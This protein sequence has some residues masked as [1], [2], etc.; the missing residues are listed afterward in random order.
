MLVTVGTDDQEPG[1]FDLG[2]I[3]K[4]RLDEEE[5]LA[6][7]DFW[8]IEDVEEPSDA[9][10]LDGPTHSGG[11]DNQLAAG[12]RPFVWGEHEDAD[13]NPSGAMEMAV[14]RAVN[15]DPLRI[16][17]KQTNHVALLTAEEE[18]DLGKR[19]EAG[20]YAAERL[21]ASRQ[22]AESLDSELRHDLECIQREGECAKK[23]LIEA[24]LRLVVSIARRYRALGLP[25]MDLI[26]EGNLGLIRAVQKFDYTKGFEVSTYATWWIR[27]AITRG[28]ADS[29]RVIRLPV[30]V[31]EHVN[32]VQQLERGYLAEHGALPTA[33]WLAESLHVGA[34]QVEHLRDIALTT[35]AGISWSRFSIPT[36]RAGWMR[37]MSARRL[38]RILSSIESA[39]RCCGAPFV[40]WGIG[41]GTSCSCGSDG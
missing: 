35:S 10:Q 7:L 21:R 36:I 18:V 38:R 31:V 27:Q 23:Q 19:I 26:Q 24:N 14:A 33:C 9:G 4:L 8:E 6:D 32:A 13:R 28:L 17:L 16:Y 40:R 15:N 1:D 20:L 37:S 25:L 34:D 41:P 3:E 29:A 30:H 12:R 22:A 39:T 11:G 5:Q 2:A